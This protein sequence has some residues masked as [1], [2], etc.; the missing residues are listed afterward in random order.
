M[1]IRGENSGPRILRRA[2]EVRTLRLA[3]RWLL[4]RGS[5]SPSEE[6]HSR[7]WPRGPS[8]LHCTR[9]RPSIGPIPKRKSLR[10]MDDIAQ[11]RWGL[12]PTPPAFPRLGG[13]GESRVLASALDNRN[14]HIPSRLIGT[15]TSRF[16][17]GLL[18]RLG[19]ISR[20]LGRVQCVPHRTAAEELTRPV[21]SLWQA[22]PLRCRLRRP[23]NPAS[24][25]RERPRRP[26][27][28]GVDQ[29]SSGIAQAEMQ[30]T[31]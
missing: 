5:Y 29:V 17:A 15:V 26:L 13:P 4:D 30:E 18:L 28:G 11:S 21:S 1:K 14:I 22:L 3:R 27:R 7:A 9:I 8:I 20:Y 10:F 23:P 31:R 25:G 16:A 6:R 2:C 12:T 24:L 19:Y